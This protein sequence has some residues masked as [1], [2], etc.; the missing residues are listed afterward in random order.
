[1]NRLEPKPQRSASILVVVLL[2]LLAALLQWVFFTHQMQAPDGG[3]AALAAAEL[4][5]TGVTNPVTAVLLNYRAVDTL[6]ELA[7]LL[8]ALLGIWALGA[9]ARGYQRA[10][11]VYAGMVSWVVPL[12]ILTAGYLL[13]IGAKAPGGA[14][15]AGAL[16][17]AAGVILRLGGSARGGLPG[18]S[19]QRWLAVA[20][21]GV[22]AL[23][24]LATMLAGRGFLNYP[25]PW[26]G[27]LIL[28]IETFAT[29]TIATLLTAAYVGNEE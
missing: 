14:F 2:A 28:L 17:A 29:L 15:Q 16:L 13:W 23:V 18:A 25:E 3:L 21:I 22:F 6:L 27:W 8:A 10:G 1:M 5:R 9:P 19:A 12:L 20:G 4:P 11:P 7:V 24:G 26:A